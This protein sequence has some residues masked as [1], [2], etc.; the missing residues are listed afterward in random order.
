MKKTLGFCIA[1]IVVIAT[2]ITVGIYVAIIGGA[3]YGI[4]RLVKYIKKRREAKEW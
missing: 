1:F 2:L 3:I 4:Y